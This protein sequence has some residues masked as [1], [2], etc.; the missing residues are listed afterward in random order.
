MQAAPCTTAEQSSC[1]GVSSFAF[2][3]TNAHVLLRAAVASVSGSVSLA[4]ERLMGVAHTIYFSL[5][6]D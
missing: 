1:R 6:I 2:Q 4:G 5:C 3:G